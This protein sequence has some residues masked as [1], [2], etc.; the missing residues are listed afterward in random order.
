MTNRLSAGFAG[1]SIAAVVLTSSA[2]GAK[3]APVPPFGAACSATVS[4]ALAV[5]P[6]EQ[7]VNVTLSE[8]LTEQPKADIARESNIKVSSVTKGADNKNFTLKVDASGA[9]AGAWALT[10][11][12]GATSCAGEVK[13]TPAE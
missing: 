13:V 1:L 11:T 7:E 4:Q 6:G 10:L 8:E 9:A 3:P 12:G 5:R 2:V